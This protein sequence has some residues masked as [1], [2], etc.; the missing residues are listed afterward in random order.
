M[1][2]LWVIVLAVMTLLTCVSAQAAGKTLT[3]DIVILFT[4]DV[5][6]D[7]QQGWGYAGVAAMHNHLAQNHHILLVDVGDAIGDETT[8]EVEDLQTMFALMNAVGY[9]LAVPGEA[10][11]TGDASG[12]L[13]LAEELAEFPYICANLTCDGRSALAPYKMFTF[14]GVK[15]ALVGVTTPRFVSE[16]ASS[17][18]GEAFDLAHD[19]TGVAL[20]QAVQQ[21]VNAA[22]KEGASYVIVLTH[23]GD[24]VE[25]SPWTSMELISRTNG[26]DLVLDGHASEMTYGAEIMNKDGKFVVR[27][28]CGSQ[29]ANIGYAV[30]A[31][32]G[33]LETGMYEWLYEA[34][35]PQMMRSAASVVEAVEEEL[36]VQEEAVQ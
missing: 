22:R 4:G 36:S 27:A 14:D 7:V 15:V 11:L 3:K 32:D 24:A 17:D 18:Q 35:F 20:Q 2:K 29:L 16:E 26:I 9:D 10:E 30:I 13:P 33:T 23:L 25:N 5:H 31:V 28:A 1:K 6:G 8:G 12:F 34:S 21:A 19:D